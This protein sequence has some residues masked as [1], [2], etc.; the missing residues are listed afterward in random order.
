MENKNCNDNIKILME[1][2]LFYYIRVDI[3]NNLIVFNDYFKKI[4]SYSTEKLASGSILNFMHHEDYLKYYE[5]KKK[6]L[7]NWNESFLV[8]LKIID[9][10]KNDYFT[11]KW[12]FRAI[13]NSN[14]EIF[15]EAIGWD[16]TQNLHFLKQRSAQI[17]KVL[18]ILPDILLVIDED[19]VLMNIFRNAKIFF[20]Y[21]P[22]NLIGKKIHHIP[23][24]EEEKIIFIHNIQKTFTEKALQDIEYTWQSNNGTKR[25]FLANAVSVEFWGKN[26]VLWLAKDIT[27][28]K[29]TQ[30][31][32]VKR[33]EQ[34]TDIANLNAHKVRGPVATIL[35]LIQLFEPQN[36][37][38]NNQKL[39]EMMQM[40]VQKL[41][42][43]IHQ[44]IYTTY[45]NYDKS[46]YE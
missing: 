31:L 36:M 29:N 32:L 35:G 42:L 34:L 24:Q 13:Q 4:N 18:E 40:T 17:N 11:I 21:S 27:E 6:C 38:E 12:E 46:E 26:C 8:A 43:A 33:N 23:L 28:F 1:S 19:L 2:R 45:E 5:V 7:N 15:L 37:D 14:N 39:F 9:H 3:D 41:D 22:L 20:E 16:D 30:E 44:I 25:H 10:E